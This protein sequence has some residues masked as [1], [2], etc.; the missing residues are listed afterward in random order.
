M[1]ILDAA[2]GDMLWNRVDTRIESED[3]FVGLEERDG[4]L[5][6]C[7]NRGF[8]GF[9]ALSIYDSPDS[10]NPIASTEPIALE[11]S[12]DLVIFLAKSIFSNPLQRIEKKDDGGISKARCHP[13]FPNIFAFGGKDVN[14]EI[15][16]AEPD[17]FGN[18]SYSLTKIWGA[19]NVGNDE[20]NLQQP[21]WI[22]DLQFLD[23]QQWSADRGYLLAVCT[24]FRQVHS[25]NKAADQVGPPL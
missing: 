23:Q 10:E 12:P 15:W 22:S 25:F 14:L 18:E 6:W 2:T 9:T 20:Y 4:R 3:P 16:G 8:I 5:F 19:K 7:T 13:R 11:I 1:Q 24:R 21:V 17:P